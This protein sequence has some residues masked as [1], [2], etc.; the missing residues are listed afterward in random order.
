VNALVLELPGNA[1]LVAGLRARLGAE[2]GSF[3]LRRF[4]D[5][6]IIS[7]G[8][9]MLATIRELRRLGMASPVAVGVHAVFA[10]GAY[11]ELLAVR[12]ARV[13]TCNTIPDPSNGIPVDD[14]LASGVR[15]MLGGN[16]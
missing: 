4:P 9:T 16:A 13:V 14:L 12:P 8:Q 15:G 7:T 6:D 10:E 11:E 2:Q 5:G 1:A 3:T